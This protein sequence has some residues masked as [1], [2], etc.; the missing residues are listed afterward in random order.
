MGKIFH[1]GQIG[2]EGL[3]RN[4]GHNWFPGIWWGGFK[5]LG[6]HLRK[7]FWKKV[8]KKGFSFPLVGLTSGRILGTLFQERDE[9]GA[10]V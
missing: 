9:V 5:G 7:E 8:G 10:E 6:P 1:F 4:L 2:K 3:L